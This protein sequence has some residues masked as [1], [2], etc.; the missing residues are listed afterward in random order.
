MDGQLIGPNFITNNVVPRFI[1]TL[2][3]N[4]AVGVTTTGTNGVIA[5]GA[6]IHEPTVTFSNINTVSIGSRN[7]SSSHTNNTTYDLP[8]E[9]RLD[10]VA[11]YNY[12]LT[13]AQVF[14]HYAVGANLSS[15]LL[16]ITELSSNKQMLT[17]LTAAG[18]QSSTNA[19][20]PWTNIVSAS[21]PYTNTAGPTKQFFRLK[22]H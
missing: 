14:S 15:I 8:F 22:V 9:G 18:L 7:K 3:T 21:S 4:H 5:A 10:E 13:P 20:D 6:G 16:T 17:W 2:D 11:L 12:P 1:F 19:N